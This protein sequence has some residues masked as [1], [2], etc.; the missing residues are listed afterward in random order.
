MDLDSSKTSKHN[1]YSLAHIVRRK[2]CLLGDVG[3]L[4]NDVV[5]TVLQ[6]CEKQ[7]ES[8][9]AVGFVMASLFSGRNLSQLLEAETSLPSNPRAE[10]VENGFFINSIWQ[11]PE[12]KIPSIHKYLFRV[13]DGPG[14]ILLPLKLLPAF[15]A[16]KEDAQSIENLSEY[17]TQFCKQYLRGLF[18]HVNITRLQLHLAHSAPKY[19]LNRAEVAY[20]ADHD[21]KYNN[22]CAYG[23]FDSN[24]V[25]QK[26]IHFINSLTTE[27]S[28]TTFQVQTL[29]KECFVGSCRVANDSAVEM[30]FKHCCN[31]INPK[32][33]T[34]NE[35]VN[36][37][38]F[39][40]M[41]VVFFLELCTLHRP[42]VSEFGTLKH[43]DLI[44]GSLVICDKGSKSTRLVYL[45]VIAIEI[46][47]TYLSFIRNLT[48]KLQFIY[49]HISNTLS[50]ILSGQTNLF[51]LWNSSG[52]R[53]YH[54]KHAFSLIGAK[55]PFP[56]N[57]ARHFV[58]TFLMQKGFSR[59]E[60]EVFMG[61]APAP[62][63]LHS[64]FSS[65]KFSTN[66]AI[67][68]EIENY[69]VS[70]LELPLI[71]NSMEVKSWKTR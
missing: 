20:I 56:V 17:V 61:H 33:T 57:W 43:F 59:N 38:N 15:Q 63:T 41:Y 12:L 10:D 21:L 60:L 34:Q 70:T 62:D 42:I 44:S 6:R 9:P 16:A 28:L 55:F 65:Y 31:F 51:N 3:C 29:E 23:L 35:I 52:L 24:K 47:H 69:I 45:P 37:F 19:N 71:V 49:P 11:Y 1:S 26:H 13:A 53:P 5:T 14:Q 18:Q 66:R 4:T 64:A 7:L 8:N 22:Q 50:R 27:A 68:R 2:K 30:L 67:S 46:L 54:A 39:Y 58:A 32:P 48:Y 25:V 40:T 36:T